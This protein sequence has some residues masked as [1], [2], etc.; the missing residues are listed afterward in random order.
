[1]L[2]SLPLVGR[3]P[4]PEDRRRAHSGECVLEEL[5]ALLRQLDLPQVQAGGK[6]CPGLPFTSTLPASAAET[7]HGEL[8]IRQH[9]ITV[10]P[11]VPSLS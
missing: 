3:Y 10:A 8:T 4:V 6:P 11:A 9:V 2:R 7:C 5:Q 1:M